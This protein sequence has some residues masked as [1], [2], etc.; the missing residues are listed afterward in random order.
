MS[1]ASA[2][3]TPRRIAPRAKLFTLP[4]CASLAVARTAASS[5]RTPKAPNRPE[6]S[7]ILRIQVKTTLHHR[8]LVVHLHSVPYARILR[9]EP[10]MAKASTQ[11]TWALATSKP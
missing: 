6:T 11:T 1:S 3:G 9:G 10:S 5:L 4:N 8:S 2:F 7:S